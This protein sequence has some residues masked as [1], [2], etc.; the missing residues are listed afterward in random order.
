MT[1]ITVFL[2][3]EKFA[4]D[5]PVKQIV[6]DKKVYKD[7]VER[8][9]KLL[10]KGKDIGTL[11]VVKHPKK[12]LY[13]VLDGHHRFWALKEMGAKHVKCAVVIDYYGLTFELTKKGFYQPSP[14]IT[15]KLR[16]PVH[17]WGKEMVCYLNEFKKDPLRMLGDRVEALSLIK[18]KKKPLEDDDLI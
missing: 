12:D 15:K 11:I 2:N 8:Y 18:R 5:I 13:A 9:K 3:P 14:E 16:V 7:G 17:E 6:A 1:A 10:K 4:Q